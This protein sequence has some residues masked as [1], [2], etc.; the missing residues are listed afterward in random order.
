MKNA[1]KKIRRFLKLSRADQLL[2]IETVLWLWVI[3]LGLR[4]LPLLTVQRLLQKVADWR[5]RSSN[6]QQI[7]WAILTGSQ[8]VPEAACLQQALA[9]KFLLIQSGYAAELQ[10]GATLHPDGTLE[11][12]AWVTG[13]D[14]IF[15]GDLPDLERFVPLSASRR[16]L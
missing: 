6:A 7:T 8:F 2:L 11:A 10:I 13:E 16:A 4:V 15:I 14:G 5:S 3:T 12:H 9:A 1:V